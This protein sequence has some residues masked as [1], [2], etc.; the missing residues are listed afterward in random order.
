MII[1][2]KLDASRSLADLQAIRYAAFCSTMIMKNVI[3][4][5]A[6]FRQISEEDA[7]AKI[8]EFLRSDELP[9]LNNRPRIILAAGSIR[10]QELTSCVL[11]LRNFGIDISCV[12]L[13][14][15]RLPDYDQILL[16][17]RI[18]IPLP[19]AKDI[20]IR[21]EQKEAHLVQQARQRSEFKR[22]WQ[23]ISY[24]FNKFGMQ[25]Q[26][27]G[28]STGIF[29]QMCIENSRHHYEWYINTKNRYLEIALHFEDSDHQENHHL[30]SLIQK[31]QS[32]IKKGIHLDF[33]ISAKK[34]G[35]AAFCLPYEGEYPTT[36]IAPEA[37]RF[38]RLLIERTWPI[39]E[40]HF[41]K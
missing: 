15:Y 40:P 18:L 24:E 32:E 10:D 11:W 7:A 3:E 28:E 29:Q 13:T 26:A 1:E 2:L 21:I 14:P 39:I 22:L 16:A 25:F 19:E 30:I 8:S 17:P 34:W 37:A 41:R 5:L 6:G 12:E 20:Q 9:E 38:M 4:L 33:R 31:N 27:N 36:D 35:Q 23:T